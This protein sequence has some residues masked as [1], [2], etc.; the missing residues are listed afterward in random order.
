MKIRAL[1]KKDLENLY[2]IYSDPEIVSNNS[3]LPYISRDDFDAMFDFESGNQL[4]FVC[5]DDQNV[6]EGHL[7]IQVS[8]KPRMRHVVTFGLAIGSDSRGRGLG[9]ELVNFLTEYCD[10]WLNVSRIELDVH[11]DNEGAISLYKSFGFDI[12][13]K[14]RCAVFVNGHY[15]DVIMMA[16]LTGLNCADD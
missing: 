10:N 11:A 9:R 2:V 7:S 12:E 3:Y 13:G 15:A 6:P 16:R 4:N 5:T 14:R 8:G 1:E